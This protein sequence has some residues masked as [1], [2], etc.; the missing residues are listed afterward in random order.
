MDAELPLARV[1]SMTRLF[2]L[3]NGGD[4]LFVRALAGF[5][6][7]ALILAA[8]G[9][10][11]LVAYSVRQRSHEIGIR[12]ALGAKSRDVLAMVL[13]EGMKMAAAGGSIGLL[14]AL[15]LPKLFTAIL[16]DFHVNEPRL[17]LAV[18]VAI[19]VIAMF[20]TYIPARRAAHVDP[21]RALR[22]E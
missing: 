9:I 5:A 22:Q 7:M 14:I 10:Y 15:P 21:M 6:L 20:A 11:G 1:M 8:I 19:L 13:G 4:E 18:P 12:M 16:F 3:Q 17:Y 2:D